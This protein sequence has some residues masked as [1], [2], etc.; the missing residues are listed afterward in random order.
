MTYP[1]Q[2]RL[3]GCNVEIVPAMQHILVDG[4][5]YMAKEVVYRQE[6]L[7]NPSFLPMLF[8]FSWE[9]RVHLLVTMYAQEYPISLQEDAPYHQYSVHGRGSEKLMISHRYG[10]GTI[11]VD[12][13]ARVVNVR[14][15]GLGLT[16]ASSMA[17]HYTHE[18]SALSNVLMDI[19]VQE[20]AAIIAW[21]LRATREEKDDILLLG[22]VV[23]ELSMD[24]IQNRLGPIQETPLC[25]G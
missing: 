23:G 20:P 6:S 12:K 1:I 22:S 18:L 7:W 13:I 16:Y 4:L 21:Y 15:S 14:E 9:E 11:M 25:W 5:L 19:S 10:H 24:L 17:S 8:C 3:H 2:W